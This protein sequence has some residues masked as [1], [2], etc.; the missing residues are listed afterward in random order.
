MHTNYTAACVFRLR[1]PLDLNIVIHNQARAIR[2]PLS[3]QCVRYPRDKAFWCVPAAPPDAAAYNDCP[4]SMQAASLGVAPPIRPVRALCAFCVGT[5]RRHR[6]ARTSPCSHGNKRALSYRPSACRPLFWSEK[7]GARV[8]R[9][10]SCASSCDSWVAGPRV[11]LRFWGKDRSVILSPATVG[12]RVE[13]SLLTP[14]AMHTVLL[15]MF[16]A[17]KGGF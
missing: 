11:A 7:S 12:I 2:I 3:R 17:R 13:G 10:R 8:P 1:P 14:F 16:K 9:R 4:L 6:R 15:S 5:P